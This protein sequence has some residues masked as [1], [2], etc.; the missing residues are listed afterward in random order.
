MRKV[1]KRN[2]ETI[3]SLNELL[4]GEYM[5][6]ESFNNFISKVESEKLIQIFKDVQ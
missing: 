3:K 1:D 2:A 5:A 4:Q 6:L